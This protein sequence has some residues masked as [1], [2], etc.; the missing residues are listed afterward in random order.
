MSVSSQKPRFSNRFWQIAE[1]FNKIEYENNLLL[2][3]MARIF[4]VTASLP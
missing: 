3:K 1:K 2:K 4:Q